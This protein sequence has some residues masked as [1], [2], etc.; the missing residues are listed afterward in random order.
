MELEFLHRF[1]QNTQSTKSN[2][3]PVGTELLNADGEVDGRTD[4]TKI[5]SGFSR[6]CQCA[7]KTTLNLKDKVQLL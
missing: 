1:W 7:L 2:T 3:L 6:F 5:N 4:M